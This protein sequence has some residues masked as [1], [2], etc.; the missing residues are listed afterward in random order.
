MKAR[1]TVLVAIGAGVGFTSVA[2]G[3]GVPWHLFVPAITVVA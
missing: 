2:A 3:Q 1:Y